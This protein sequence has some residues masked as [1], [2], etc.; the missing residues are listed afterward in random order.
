M[1][2]EELEEEAGVSIVKVAGVSAIW[3]KDRSKGIMFFGTGV[4]V[5]DENIELLA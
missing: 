1:L 4:V 2:Q 5:C 3:G